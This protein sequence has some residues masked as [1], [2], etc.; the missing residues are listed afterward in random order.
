LFQPSGIGPGALLQRRGI[1]VAHELS[2]VGE[3]LQDHCGAASST[4][5]RRAYAR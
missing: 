3:N 5:A 2:G 1:A 4:G